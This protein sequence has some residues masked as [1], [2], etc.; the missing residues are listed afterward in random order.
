ML[1]RV[2]AKWADL[3]LASK[4]L[5][6]YLVLLSVVCC[7]TVAAM[8]INLNVYDEK[9]Y[10]KSL[11]E[12]D[13]F[14]QQVNGSL[15][16]VEAFSYNLAM[17]VEIQQQLSTMKSLSHLQGE[18]QYQQYQLRSR[19]ASE[20][21]SHPIVKSITYTDQYKSEL[22]VG[23][24]NYVPRM[25]VSQFMRDKQQRE[26]NLLWATDADTLQEQAQWCAKLCKEGQE[27]YSEALDTCQAQSL[28]L[29]ES[30]RRLLRDS[31]LLQIQ[32]YYHC[33]RGAALTC[34]SLIEA[35]DGVYQQAF[36]HAGLARE[37][38]LAANAAMRSREHGKWSGFYANECLTDVKYT[39]WLLGHYMGYLRNL[40]DGPYFYGWQ[41]E[42][43]YPPEDS[44]V[45]LI[46]NMDNH[47][48]DLELFTLIK[49]KW[50]R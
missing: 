9:L 24:Y 30:P 14:V 43:L 25:L 40:G 50:E 33:Y 20:V 22:I 29:P 26:S 36:Y 38:Y 34:Q 16:E 21:Y 17:S 10:E 44:R 23:Q 42:F 6:V 37:E 28:H 13:F 19:L 48:T 27:R 2:T 47:L 3:R 8:Q 12:L 18:Y 39:A 5:L 49:E 15:A 35:L 32:I 4:M 45:V 46:T 1:R 31:I 41:R 7:V 11:Q